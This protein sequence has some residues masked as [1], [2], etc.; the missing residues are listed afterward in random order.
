MEETCN[1]ERFLPL[2]LL[3]S[4][5]YESYIATNWTGSSYILVFT[6]KGMLSPFSPHCNFVL[7]YF[8]KCGTHVSESL[9]RRRRESRT[10][11]LPRKVF[12][13]LVRENR[14]VFTEP[15]SLV[16]CFFFFFWMFEESVFH[17][18]VTY[19]YLLIIVHS[20]VMFAVPSERDRCYCRRVS[21]YHGKTYC[22][23]NGVI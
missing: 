12:C 22:W 18:C 10:P 19:V 13:Q 4:P 3:F 16:S 17:A 21:L 7:H 2:C 5:S 8:P 11:A 1:P 15:S 14:L 20:I 6:R 23:I 9:N